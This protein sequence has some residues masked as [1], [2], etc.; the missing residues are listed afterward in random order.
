[1][2]PLIY[3]GS[4]EG[5]DHKEPLRYLP[6]TKGTGYKNQTRPAEISPKRPVGKSIKGQTTFLMGGPVRATV[7]IK[8]LQMVS[9]PGSECFSFNLFNYRRML[10]GYFSRYSEIFGLQTSRRGRALLKIKVP[11]KDSGE[12]PPL[13]KNLSVDGSLK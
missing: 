7:E 10:P 13:V 2:L 9:E 3:F 1:M 4:A 6:I 5:N 11:K 12:E 8:T